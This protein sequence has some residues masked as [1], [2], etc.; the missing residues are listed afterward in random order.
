MLKSAE[1]RYLTKKQMKIFR[2][3]LNEEKLTIKQIPIN[4]EIEIYEL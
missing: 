4:S 3:S 2:Q 1:F